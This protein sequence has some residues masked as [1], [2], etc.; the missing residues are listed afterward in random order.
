MST[1]TLAIIVA[2]ISS[3]LLVYAYRKA[4]E[5]VDGSP[6]T[7]DGIR[8]QPAGSRHLEQLKEL[9]ER[10][11]E[12][13]KQDVIA[14]SVE[15]ERPT[16]QIHVT[17]THHHDYFTETWAWELP[18]HVIEEWLHWSTGGPPKESIHKP[19][20]IEKLLREIEKSHPP[21]PESEF[22]ETPSWQ[23]QH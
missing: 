14:L 12:L 3:G 15:P 20:A 18:R 13:E 11:A 21:F 6:S 23:K 1:Y 4:R 8:D 7:S 16:A 17:P 9:Q 22:D 19:N 5:I 10:V 2:A